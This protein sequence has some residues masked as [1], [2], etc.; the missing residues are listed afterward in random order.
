MKFLPDTKLQCQIETPDLRT[1]V[2]GI[3][4]KA[5]PDGSFDLY[6]CGSHYSYMGGMLTVEP[7]WDKKEMDRIGPEDDLWH[8]Y[9]DDK[10]IAIKFID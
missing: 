3:V 6:C 9:V 5:Y 4:A 7:R 8:V 10:K 2:F 1:W